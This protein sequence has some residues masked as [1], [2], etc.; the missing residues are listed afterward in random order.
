MAN[1][2]IEFRELL[3]KRKRSGKNGN[4]KMRNRKTPSLAVRL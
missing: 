2:A 4:L 1:V 3:E